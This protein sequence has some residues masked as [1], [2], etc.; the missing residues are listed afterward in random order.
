MA[1]SELEEIKRHFNVVAESLESKI[2]LVAEAVT[3]VSGRIDGVDERLVSLEQR[4][5]REITSLRAEMR[6]GFAETQAM[7]KFSYAELDRRV[8]SLETIVSNLDTRLRRLEA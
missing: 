6:N 5:D 2:K 4:I 8:T 3:G 1:S 7:I